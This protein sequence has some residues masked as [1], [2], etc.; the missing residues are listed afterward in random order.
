[1][2]DSAQAGQ[3]EQ[4]RQ[5]AQVLLQQATRSDWSFS[6]VAHYYSDRYTISGIET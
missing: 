3:L 6:R 1:M 2:L 5:T 4:A